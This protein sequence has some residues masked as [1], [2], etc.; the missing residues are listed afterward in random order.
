M[1]HCAAI[2]I[3]VNPA[4]QPGLDTLSWWLEDNHYS[5]HARERILAHA[6]AEGTPTGCR[7]LEREDEAGAEAVFVD[8]LPPLEYSNPAWGSLEDL[9][10][11]DVPPVSGGA[12]EDEPEPAAL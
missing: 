2:P 9:D 8:A 3:F 7:Y 11:L 5:A 1:G 10:G 6:A 4:L 12:P